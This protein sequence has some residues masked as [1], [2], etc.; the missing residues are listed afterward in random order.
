[1]S[2]LSQRALAAL[3]DGSCW[4]R[5]NL[6]TL[7]VLAAGT[8][9]FLLSTLALAPG[10][11]FHPDE[12]TNLRM[13]ALREQGVDAER[14]HATF[15]GFYKWWLGLGFSERHARLPSIAAATLA[16]VLFW[17]LCWRLGGRGAALAGMVVF[18]AWPRAWDDALEMRYYAVILMAAMAGLHLLAFS[19]RG[20]VLLPGLGMA[21]LVALLVFWHPTPLPFHGGLLVLSGVYTLMAI[22]RG[23]PRPWALA[24]PV[25]WLVLMVVGAVVAMPRVR[26]EFGHAIA[27]ESLLETGPEAMLR[28]LATWFFA[29]VD[30]V[31]A[32]PWPGRWVLRASLLALAGAGVV[33]LW[34]R[35]RWML[36]CGVAL[37]LIQYVAVMISNQSLERLAR[38]PK[39]MT[40]AGAL[41]MLAVAMGMA[42][43]VEAAGRRHPRGAMLAMA[44]VALLYVAPL[45]PRLYKSIA[46]DGSRYRDLW[47]VLAREAPGRTPLLFASTETTQAIPFYRYLLPELPLRPGFDHLVGRGAIP[48]LVCR[49]EPVFLAYSPKRLEGLPGVELY[50][51]V[52]A[53]ESNFSDSWHVTVL[54]PRG[55]RR[56]AGGAALDLVAG[57][58]N[59]L[60]VEDGRWQ[61]EGE[62]D[63]TIDGKWLQPGSIISLEAG[64]MLQVEATSG[65][66]RLVPAADAPARRSAVY[67][68][69]G[70]L[71]QYDRPELLDGRP[72]YR[73][74]GNHA[75]HYELWSPREP[76]VLAIEILHDLPVN[77]GFMLSID[78]CVE[79]VFVDAEGPEPG[80][81]VL[82]IHEIPAAKRGRPIRVGITHAGESQRGAPDDDTVRSLKLVSLSV[83]PT[84]LGTPPA[85]GGGLDPTKFPPAADWMPAN[86][87]LDF[88]QADHSALWLTTPVP[89]PHPVPRRT[90]SGLSIRLPAAMQ[91]QLIQLPPMKVPEGAQLLFEF[92]ARTRNILRKDAV[93]A[94]I[95]VTAEGAVQAML[96]LTQQGID[97]DTTQWTTYRFISEARPGAPIVIFGFF[98]NSPEAERLRD[99]A[100]LELEYWRMAVREP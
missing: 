36:W 26:A 85:T 97:R 11:S 98:L 96:Q 55:H 91:S 60:V 68:L 59:V 79:Q 75:V 65:I 16:M 49:E 1:M 29:W 73:L 69:D 13:H 94:L 9:L 47:A 46:L 7:A 77:G 45:A 5:A 6:T 24:G 57:R 35:Q 23:W 76:A 48:Y 90:Q 86:G 71:G 72:I 31:M 41:V 25:T 63:A 74:T 19:R 62:G 10:R 70:P 64:A 8:L 15:H 39:Y 34:R 20:W 33:A 21:G 4:A 81:P 44:A 54:R 87:I 80:E 42:W 32:T 27:A 18:L 56:L 30:D 89:P 88:T 61:L 66:V 53:L 38:A 22:R 51:P 12:L 82:Y 83:V 52:A 37:L 50:Q 3:K 99:D 28:P 2:V 17:S 40:S 43:A 93:P 58:R 100:T 92:R 95:H 67:T 84:R 14:V 78:D